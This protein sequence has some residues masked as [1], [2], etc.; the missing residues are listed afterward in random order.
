[1]SLRTKSTFIGRY[2]KRKSLKDKEIKHP[3]PGKYAKIRPGQ[4]NY[5]VTAHKGHSLISVVNKRTN[6]IE[7][8]IDRKLVDNAE[9]SHGSYIHVTHEMM[10]NRL[11]AKLE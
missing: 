10:R 8:Y 9:Y 11:R 3:L 1:M 5:S 4:L 6:T 7:G 2:I